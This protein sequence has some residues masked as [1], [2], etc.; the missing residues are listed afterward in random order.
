MK[1][2]LQP[3]LSQPLAALAPKTASGGK[4]RARR[5]A[6]AW[7][8]DKPLY[9]FGKIRHRSQT[10]VGHPILA[11]TIGNLVADGIAGGRKSKAEDRSGRIY[12]PETG[13]EIIIP[14]ARESARYLAESAAFQTASLGV[15]N[16]LLA[17]T[18]T[19]MMLALN[20]VD[21][22]LQ[23]QQRV[24][25]DGGV[26][27]TE[28]EEDSFTGITVTAPKKHTAAWDALV[29]L[30]QKSGA[31]ALAAANYAQRHVLPRSF[32][33]CYAYVKR[34]LLAAGVAPNYLSGVAAKSAGP[35]LESLGYK[36]LLGNGDY[37]SPYDAPEGAIIVYDATRDARFN[38]RDKG[39]PFGH[40]EFRTHDGFASDYFSRNARTGAPSNG[41][42]G[43]G[44]TVIG[45]YV[46]P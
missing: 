29:K 46:K 26:V 1:G 14:S 22:S 12:N 34:A 39:W 25:S 45:I 13:E 38:P 15:G 20:D 9:R 2:A 42:T 30:G 6:P 7:S 32:G 31:D 21:P 28:A 36:N 23:G 16:D 17:V 41:M 10:R 3:S 40:I 43:R 5:F 8:A 11:N 4:I 19:G 18:E 35:N 24:V 27:A 33:K 37:R 44:R